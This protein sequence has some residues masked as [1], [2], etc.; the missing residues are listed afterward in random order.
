MPR[1]PAESGE[2]ELADGPVVHGHLPLA[3]E[4]VDLHRGLVVLGGGEDLRLLG[5]DGRVPRDQHGG[6]AAQRLDAERER[7]HVEQEHVLDLAAEHTALN[8]GAD[9]DDLVGLTDLL[10]SL[11]KKSLTICWIF[12]IRVLPPTRMT[13]SIC[14]GSSPRPSAPAAWAGGSAGSGRP[15]AA[16]TW[17]G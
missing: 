12:G 15:P 5:R 2:L 7:G 1:E 16:R 4:H 8:G 14:L 10:G 6:D 13:S 11:P 17:P 3:L 9:G